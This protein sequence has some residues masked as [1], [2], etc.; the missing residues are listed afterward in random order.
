M[1]NVF[2]YKQ[3]KVYFKS[4]FGIS[5]NYSADFLYYCAI[6]QMIKK[7]AVAAKIHL[8]I[9]FQIGICSLA[10]PGRRTRRPNSQPTPSLT[11]ADL[12]FYMPKR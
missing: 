5:I 4:L 1:F 7:E 6:T 12:C 10:D 3:Q 2:I 9:K 8:N 11:A